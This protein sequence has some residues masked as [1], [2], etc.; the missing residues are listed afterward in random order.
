MQQMRG[1]T[2]AA[3]P[4]AEGG[5]GGAKAFGAMYLHSNEAIF[6]DYLLRQEVCANRRL[7]L[8]AKLPRNVLVHQRSLAD[9]VTESRPGQEGAGASSQRC[10]EAGEGVGK[11]KRGWRGRGGR[12][13]TRGT[14]EC[15][16]QASGRAGRR[17]EGQAGV[18]GVRGVRGVA[19]HPLSPRMI[20]FSST[21]RR[22]A[23]AARPCEGGGGGAAAQ[24]RARGSIRGLGGGGGGAEVWGAGAGTAGGRRGCGRRREVTAELRGYGSTGS[25][26]PAASAAGRKVSL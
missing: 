24:S 17:A 16:R 8:A 25:H 23:I 9:T 13:G 1:P 18:R 3:E 4:H 5:L 2:T 7:V 19:P 26:V 12:G 10:V 22:D 11:I 14:V 21:L 6:H 20:T 15:S